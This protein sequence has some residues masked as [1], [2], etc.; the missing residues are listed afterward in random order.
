MQARRAAVAAFNAG[1]THSQEGPRADPGEV[2]HQLHHH[3]S[4]PGR[5]PGPRLCRRLD[6]AQ[7]WRHRDGPGADDQGRPGRRRRVRSWRGGG[8]G[9]R[10]AHRQG[11]QHL[12]HRRLVGRRPER[13]GRAARRRSTIRDRLAALAASDFGCEA[14]EIAFAGGEVVRQWQELRLR[15]SLP[16]RASRPHLARRDRLLRD[17]GAS[18]TTAPAIAA[19]PSSISLMARR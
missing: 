10:D 18:S 12:G 2:R 15:R 1:H 8:E 5:R 13:H 16:P 3:P 11:A 9:H 19:A 14:G 17:A 4:Q 6:P 7:P